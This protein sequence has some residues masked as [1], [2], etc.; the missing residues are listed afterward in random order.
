MSVDVYSFLCMFPDSQM[1][2]CHHILW[3]IN[4]IHQGLIMS[5][6]NYRRS[7]IYKLLQ[8]FQSICCYLT[9]LN[10]C[11]NFLQG[12]TKRSW[13]L[14]RESGGQA[15]R[16]VW[17]LNENEGVRE[18]ARH[19]LI[20]FL[21]WADGHLCC[22]HHLLIVKLRLLH[23]IF[24][25]WVEAALSHQCLWRS[26]G[27]WKDEQLCYRATVSSFWRRNL[28]KWHDF[29]YCEHQYSKVLNIAFSS[30]MRLQVVSVF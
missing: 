7:S 4:Y 28:P 1:Q 24:F 6:I 12:M 30:V 11:P 15:L 16:S 18:N 20:P 29:Y 13:K 14:G 2:D 22:S 21:C 8:I 5:K 19:W 25:Y 9:S 23:L 10:D 17:D 27:L 26:K 3:P